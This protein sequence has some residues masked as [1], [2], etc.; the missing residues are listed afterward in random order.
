MSQDS[1]RTV[2]Q[3]I[4]D[5]GT[6]SAETDLRPEL[7]ENSRQSPARP[8]D[9]LPMIQRC[10]A[11]QAGK[12]ERC[13]CGELVRVDMI[14]WHRRYLEHTPIHAESWP[15]ALISNLVLIAGLLALAIALIGV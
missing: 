14:F 12:A 8:H 9:S 6:V 4:R 15:W 13:V 11:G 7:G 2:R 3:P 5:P 10:A 1:V